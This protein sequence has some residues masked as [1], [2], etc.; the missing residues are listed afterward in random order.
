MKLFASG[1]VRVGKKPVASNLPDGT[2]V[3][4][5]SAVIDSIGKG[6]EEKPVWGTFKVYGKRAEPI[7]KYVD[8]GHLIQVVQASIRMN[9]F[10]TRDGIKV[11]AMEFIVNDYQLMP[12]L[13]RDSGPI[14]VADSGEP[15]VESTDDVPY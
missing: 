6:N 10:E 12:N 9:E 4:K 14:N 3:V 2:L 7:E 5:F 11:S 8:K 1:V 15:P 13:R